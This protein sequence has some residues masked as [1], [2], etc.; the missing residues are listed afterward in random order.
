[1][2]AAEHT[3]SGVQANLAAISHESIVGKVTDVL[4]EAIWNG[5]L[6]PGTR[7]VERDLATKLEVSRAPLR[8]ALRLLERDGLVVMEP[9]R[10]VRVRTLTAT[11]VEELYELRAAIEGLATELAIERATDT[12][13]A[14]LNEMV[15][16]TASTAQGSTTSPIDD[17]WEFHRALVRTAGSKRL[18]QAW[19]NIGGE[20]RLALA[21]STAELFTHNYNEQTH[22][23]LL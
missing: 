7:L 15:K 23:E 9:R 10:G 8:E 13:L 12:E 2:T 6:T 1:M 17:D 21:R 16:K 18:L 19:E 20:I 14:T 4:R 22:G 11:D 5:E 3:E